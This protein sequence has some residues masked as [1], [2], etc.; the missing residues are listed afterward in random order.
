MST[1]NMDGR[2]RSAAGADAAAT[3]D[4]TTSPVS[5]NPSKLPS[6]EETMMAGGYYFGGSQLS[7]L[8]A[9]YAEESEV[10]TSPSTVAAPPKAEASSPTPTAAAAAAATTTTATAPTPP[11]A[12][13]ATTVN[14]TTDAAVGASARKVVASL[15]SITGAT[16]TPSDSNANSTHATP[17][18]AQAQHHAHRQ[19]HRTTITEASTAAQQHQ[20]PERPKMTATRAA[21]TPPT[22]CAVAATT[23]TATAGPAAP[24]HL[25]LPLP[26]NAADSSVHSSP[27]PAADTHDASCSTMS[28]KAKSYPAPPLP[29]KPATDNA[30]PTSQARRRYTAATTRAAPPPLSPK[31]DSFSPMRRVSVTPLTSPAAGGTGSAGPAT[32]DAGA[33]SAVP[34]LLTSRLF[35]ANT[36]AGNAATPVNSLNGTTPLA[37]GG[38][39][40]AFLRP[41]P[42]PQLATTPLN[43]ATA[44]SATGSLRT[45][46]VGHR[47]R[48]ESRRTTPLDR[49]PEKKQQAEEAVLEEVRRAADDS[50]PSESVPL[51]LAQ[52]NTVLVKHNAPRTP[53]SMD[54]S[55][56]HGEL[57]NHRTFSQTVTSSVEDWL[58]PCHRPKGTHSNFYA[59]QQHQQDQ[60]QLQH[61]AARAVDL[62]P[63]VTAA[64]HDQL[65]REEMG[66]ASYSQTSL[67]D[68]SN[69]VSHET[70][71]MG[72][73][74]NSDVTAS[75]SNRTAPFTGGR[76]RAEDGAPVRRQYPSRNPSIAGSVGSADNAGFVPISR[77]QRTMSPQSQRWESS[78][79]LS[80]YSSVADSSAPQQGPQPA[81]G[82]ANTAGGAPVGLVR[83]PELVSA[84]TPGSGGDIMAPVRLATHDVGS[85]A[86]ILSTSVAT[87]TTS[88]TVPLAEVTEAPLVMPPTVRAFSLQPALCSAEDLSLNMRQV[89]TPQRY[90][91]STESALGSASVLS[92]NEGPSAMRLPLARFMRNPSAGSAVNGF[93]HHQRQHQQQQQQQ[94]QPQA[95][96]Q[97]Q[98]ALTHAPMPSPSPAGRRVGPAVL[99]LRAESPLS[100]ELRTRDAAAA[101]AGGANPNSGRR[102]PSWVR[103]S[104][105][106]QPLRQG[107]VQTLDDEVDFTASLTLTPTDVVSNASRATS[108]LS[109]AAETTFVRCD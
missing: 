65:M 17:L 4:N 77:E 104:P 100:D 94:G 69:S 76:W 49:S 14:T 54:D 34:S 62:P 58:N 37:T 27:Q 101:A 11:V 105:H 51:W 44:T 74:S 59:A 97:E 28:E 21:S 12:A 3:T 20:T 68:T 45:T 60:Q 42:P 108:A 38:T 96:Q 78:G 85:V 75:A 67:T 83:R 87:M 2:S 43:A 99:S 9:A 6:I 103:Q 33:R 106:A 109:L 31:Q 15:S 30:T 56:A 1:G 39:N 35:M 92:T 25:P 32:P 84:A 73:I 19:R 79:C 47:R 36:S 23:A 57:G 10:D 64:L 98:H 53:P 61:P 95:S 66:S 63:G 93:G 52:L 50:A 80:V 7:L 71:K 41:H 18:A 102:A 55:A 81:H 91:L 24:P 40:A 13:T 22:S 90:A 88:E 48:T 26:V 70:P 46:P 5:L 89:G 16:P 82:T 86:A 107:Q 72:T 8:D 29:A